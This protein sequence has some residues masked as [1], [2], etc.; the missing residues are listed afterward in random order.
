MLGIFSRAQLHSFLFNEGFRNSATGWYSV[1][2]SCSNN[3]NFSGFGICSSFAV[4][5]REVFK[6]DVVTLSIPS[7][8]F[9]FG[10]H[11]FNCISRSHRDSMYKTIVLTIIKFQRI[12]IVDTTL[13]GIVSNTPLQSNV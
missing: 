8:H 13:L 3:V 11:I 10:Q 5:H 7:F 1:I 4:P 12:I 2:F 6:Q 9:Q